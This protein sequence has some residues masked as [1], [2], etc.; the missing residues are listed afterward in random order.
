MRRSAKKSLFFEFLV[1]LLFA[2]GV[3]NIFASDTDYDMATVSYPQQAELYDTRGASLGELDIPK[4]Y[5]SESQNYLDG[6]ADSLVIYYSKP[7]S[8]DD[9]GSIS[10]PLPNMI[11]LDWDENT[12]NSHNFY[13]EGYSSSHRDTAATCSHIIDSQTIHNSFMA[14]LKATGSKSDS[15]LSFV[16]IPSFSSLVKTAGPGKVRSFSTFED[17]GKLVKSHFD[18]NVSDRIAPVILSALS[19][20]ENNCSNIT[21]KVSEPVQIDENYAQEAFSYYLNSAKNPSQKFINLKQKAPVLIS[22]TNEISFSICG[23]E[24]PSYGDFIRFRADSW[25]WSDATSII[26]EYHWNSP[27]DYKETKRLPSPW[28]AIVNRGNKNQK[29]AKP[30]FRIVMT[31]AFQ[32]SIEM[33][34]ETPNDT[35]S[36]TIMDMQGRILR[37]GTISSK[38]TTIAPLVPGSYIVKVGM[39]FRRVNI[40][41]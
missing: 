5:Y 28:V 12:E 27:T 34:D 10:P 32:F 33:I 25:L 31:G 9:Q 6:K 11:C 38:E 4:P 14:R 26:S 22:D 16:A 19:K 3:Q 41:Q 20:E 36:Y 40:H 30:Q 35:Y 15:I 23:G 29:F 24:K 21:V 7:F 2:F 39:G 1:S 8:I 37:N 17:K 13:A 18:C